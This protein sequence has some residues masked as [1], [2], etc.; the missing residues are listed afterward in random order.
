[1]LAAARAPLSSTVEVTSLNGHG[2]C[3]V[4]HIRTGVIHVGET[5]A[6]AFQ[7]KSKSGI[8]TP[9][10]DVKLIEKRLKAVLAR[11]G[12]AGDRDES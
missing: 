12:R 4:A 6:H 1:M 7:K 2:F 11:I 9:R 3:L 10:P 8:A 5:H